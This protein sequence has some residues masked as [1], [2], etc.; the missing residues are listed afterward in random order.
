M[1]QKILVILLGIISIGIS[2]TIE[3]KF[4]KKSNLNKID[5]VLRVLKD[6]NSVSSINQINRNKYQ[7]KN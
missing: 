1:I 7:K 2:Q 4:V 6:Y 5:D 3:E